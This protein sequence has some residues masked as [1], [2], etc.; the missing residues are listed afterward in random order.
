[1]SIST[2]STREVTNILK[3][4][5]EDGAGDVIKFR[6]SVSSDDARDVTSIFDVDINSA[7]I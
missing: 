4:V 5:V 7:R 3:V 6:M 1:M 2:Y